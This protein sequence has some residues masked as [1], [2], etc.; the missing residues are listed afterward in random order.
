MGAVP[1]HQMTEEEYLLFETEATERHEYYQG[2]VFAMAGGSVEHARIM[3]NASR[4]I[5]Q[6]LK[7]KRC[8]A[9]GSDLRV[10]V[11][12]AG[13]YTYPDISI[14]CGDIKRHKGRKDTVTNPAVLIEV[15]SP[16]T[17][18]YDRGQKFDFY[19]EIPSLKEYILISS[20][21]VK[22]E[23][24]QRQESGQWLL[25]IY[26][27]PDETLQIQSIGAGIPLSEIY[28]RVSFVQP[29]SEQP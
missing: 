11:D 16:D 19:R 23:H 28:D 14:I 9:F 4:E 8:E 12:A 26:S 10:H 13:L 20:T 3:M 24:F 2:E 25:T 5:S 17:E 21:R 18:R 29:S 1:L 6:R 27:E 7:G 15:L 22:A